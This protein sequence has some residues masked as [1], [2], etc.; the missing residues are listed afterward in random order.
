MITNTTDRVAELRE[1][2]EYHARKYHV[3]DAPE[4]ADQEFDSLVDELRGLEQSHPHLREPDSPADR[5]GG[6]SESRRPRVEHL[7]PMGSL[8]N[9]FNDDEAQH[10]YEGVTTKLGYA[11]ELTTEL[12]YDGVAISLIYQNG[13]L[14]QAA[15]RGD[16]AVGEDVTDSIRE[17]RT[18]PAN[19]ASRVPGRLEVRG[20]V[21]CPLKWFAR[22]NAS[23]VLSGQPAYANPRNLAAGSIRQLDPAETAARPLAFFPYA[24]TGE[25]I[26]EIVRTQEGLITWLKLHLG[27]NTPAEY[28]N[29]PDLAS[30]LE[31][32]RNQRDRRSDLDY[33]ADGVVL[34]VADLG[35]LGD[36]GSVSNRPVGATA[37]KFPSE[38][39][40]TTLRG[41]Q[42]QV[43][44]TGAITP[45]A[46]LAPVRVAGVTIRSA[47]LHNSDY[48]ADR[49]LRIGDVVTVER[50]GDVIPRVTG[51]M[52]ERRTGGETP[53]AMPSECPSCEG[54][55]SRYEGEVKLYCTSPAC[56]GQ[57]ERRIIHY[58]GRD[59]MDID[60]LGEKM[61]SLLFKKGFVKDVADLY[62]MNRYW[63]DLRELPG[64]GF[65]KVSN[66]ARAI[67]ASR[68]RPMSKLIAA[69]GIREVG[70]TAGEILA[71]EFGTMDRLMAASREDLEALRDIGPGMAESLLRNLRNPAMVAIIDRLKAAGVRMYE[72]VESDTEASDSPAPLTGLRIVVT[73]ALQR[74]TRTEIRDVIKQA[75]G[76]PASSVSS[77]TDYLVAG[78]R[79]GSKLRKAQD[80]GVPVL[81]EDDL[82]ELIAGG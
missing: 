38:S 71:T 49:D 56:P 11:P 42:F 82:T 24:A 65:R 35:D 32:Y 61:V 52:K 79:A 25:G 48:I 37:Y 58:A 15:T 20:E 4:I 60:G 50:A 39:A 33:A 69:L 7:T 74:Y 3:L 19:L 57:A 40:R 68:S 28:C 13:M 36:M 44:R 43:G 41:V 23:R 26:P 14:V 59:Y 51:A 27:F 77:K 31:F 78:E 17:I 53:I 45:Q 54:E 22:H 8:T 72:A 34:K 70:R 75:G 29:H 12:K 6:T 64:M 46:S 16:G 63:A 62:Y 9:V 55:L 47:T 76:S 66:L 30:A 67:D 18:V 21:Y 80:L 5:I 81:S 73:G 2:I 10:W 1:L